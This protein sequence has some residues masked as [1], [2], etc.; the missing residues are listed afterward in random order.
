MPELTLENKIE[1]E[2][3]IRSHLLS[4]DFPND[5]YLVAIEAV[6]MNKDPYEDKYGYHAVKP[7]IVKVITRGGKSIVQVR[8]DN[9]ASSKYRNLVEMSKQY[10]GGQVYLV[11]DKSMVIGKDSETGV[12]ITS[13]FLNLKEAQ[14]GII[15]DSKKP[16][17][18]YAINSLFGKDYSLQIVV[19]GDS[20]QAIA[21]AAKLAYVFESPMCDYKGKNIQF[22]SQGNG[23]KS[24]KHRKDGSRRYTIDASPQVFDSEAAANAYL[25]PKPAITELKPYLQAERNIALKEKINKRLNM[26]N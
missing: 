5:K 26:V 24:K 16:S 22:T 19:D 12:E 6:S 15:D 9:T 13:L 17:L 23:L 20:Q 14:S 2:N 11:S 3:R 4:R 7:S 18:C 8:M 1:R 25:F 10:D 21:T